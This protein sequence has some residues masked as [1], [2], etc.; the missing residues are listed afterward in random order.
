M[1]LHKKFPNRAFVVK[2]DWWEDQRP[3][4]AWCRYTESVVDIEIN[5]WRSFDII[6]KDFK[7]KY[8]GRFADGPSCRNVYVYFKTPEDMTVFLLRWSN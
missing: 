3:P 8:N 6:R 5:G 4:D 7:E 2:Y 1:E